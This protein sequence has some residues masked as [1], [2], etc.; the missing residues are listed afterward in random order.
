MIARRQQTISRTAV[1]TG[2]GLFHGAD[3]RLEFC[4]APPDHGIV[5]ERT[6]VIPPG[7]IPALVEFVVPQERCT[8][9]SRHGVSVAVIEHVMAALAGLHVDNCLVRMNALEPPICDGS[10][11]AF[12][13]ALLSAGIVEQD[14]WRKVLRVEDTTIQIETERVGIAAQPSRDESYQIGFILDFGPGPIPFQTLN[15]QVT[16]TTFQTELANC[17]TFVLEHEADA[18]R[19]NGLARRA[20]P[21]NAIVFG[22]TGI[23]ENRLRR[24]DECVRHKILDCVGDFAL[25]GC[26]LIGRFSASRSGHRLNHE[27]IRQLRAAQNSLA[28]ATPS[29]PAFCPPSGV[30]HS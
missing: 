20:T 26:D 16:P 18:L 21:Q 14:A 6:D 13:E 8:V 7:R 12:V 30:A 4:P 27:I 23:I 29:G 17:R 5:F 15:V 25:A 1:V 11:Q 22:K 9:I 10:A 3:V 28:A 24:H 2:Y 19:K